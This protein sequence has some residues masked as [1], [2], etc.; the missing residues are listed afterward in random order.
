MK[1]TGITIE[2]NASGV[3]TFARI[4]L[5]KYG[6]QLKDFFA[7]NSVELDESPYDPEF[8]AKI[9]RNETQIAAGKC[10][11]IKTEDLWK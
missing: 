8:V 3:P 4:D 9:R 11:V 5:R 6:S 7:A 1:T 10:K 2:R